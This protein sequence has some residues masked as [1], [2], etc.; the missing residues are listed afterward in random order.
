M[1]ILWLMLAFAGV[2]G[3]AACGGDDKGSGTG[4]GNG[5]ETV[6]AKLPEKLIVTAIPDDADEG[7]MRENFGYI[8][9]LWQEATGIPCEYVHVQDYQASVVALATGNAHI[10]WFGAVTTAQAYMQMGDDMV[11]IGCRDIDKTF[12][13]YYIGNAAKGIPKVNDLKELGTL[14]KQN[15]WTLTFGSKN[16]TSSHMMPRSFFQQQYGD[17]PEN[18]FSNVAYSG[19]HEIVLA[20]VASGEFDVGALGQP[21]Y[22]RASEEEKARAPV[23][24]TTPTF[25]NYCFAARADLGEELLNK[26]R[27]TLLT[28]HETEEG[29]KILG[30]LGASKYIAADMSEWMGYVDLIKSGVDIGS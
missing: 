30:Y 27:Q 10:S 15:G 1:R 7:R 4:D 21:P 13:S 25:T 3:L 11:V 22:D 18:A 2:M 16:S 24:Y 8:A 6:T 12:I 23:I 20:K 29:K 28:A 17:T 9:K 26:L 5:G 19:K 14:A